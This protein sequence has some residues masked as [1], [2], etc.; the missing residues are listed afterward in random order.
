[1]NNKID[2]AA[3]AFIASV[4]RTA[5]ANLERYA[6]YGWTHESSGAVREAQRLLDAANAASRLC[7]LA[8]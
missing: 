3:A 5:A 1:M 7:G 2:P 8:G 6:T 4:Q